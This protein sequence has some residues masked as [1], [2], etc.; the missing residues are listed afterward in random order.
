MKTKLVQMAKYLLEGSVP[1]LQGLEKKKGITNLKTHT[2]SS[3][4]VDYI[5]V[6]LTRMTQVFINP[7]EQCVSV[8]NPLN[9]LVNQMCNFEVN[10]VSLRRRDEQ[11]CVSDVD[12]MAIL[13]AFWCV[14]L[15]STKL[16]CSS[17][18]FSTIISLLFTLWNI[19]QLNP[20]FTNDSNST[21]L[22]FN[23]SIMF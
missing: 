1:E 17:K 19:N 21:V 4:K 22:M 14:P 9:N 13:N 3:S 2:S 11:L 23:C 6:F 20:M 10:S 7:E 18:V 16:K 5:Q 15:Q 8:V 12:E